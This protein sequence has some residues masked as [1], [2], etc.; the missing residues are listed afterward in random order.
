MIYTWEIF[1][2]G[3]S[4]GFIRSISEYHARYWYYMN[5]GSASLYTGVGFDQI[6]AVRQ[7]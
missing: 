5:Y 4:K 3:I 2:D 1:V 7:N 6:K